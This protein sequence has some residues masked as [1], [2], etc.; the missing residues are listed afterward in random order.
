[1]REVKQ[2]PLAP[3]QKRARTDEDAERTTRAPPPDLKIDF[4][5]TTAK[6]RIITVTHTTASDEASFTVNTASANGL[7][8][9]CGGLQ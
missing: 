9:N 4:K 3:P 8:V 7:S 2:E 1:M 6:E 5:D